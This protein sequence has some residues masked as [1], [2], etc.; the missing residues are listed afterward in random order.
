MGIVY[1][2]HDPE[3]DRHVAIKILPAQ[4]GDTGELASRRLRRE[5][6]AMAKLSHPNLVPVFDVGTH[7]GHVYLA[8]EYVPGGTLRH[9]LERGGLRWTAIVDL[10]PAGR[11]RLWPPPTMRA[12]FTVTSN[13]TT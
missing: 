10:V 6:Q 7:E 4:H 2:A 12:S 9:R 1:E 3:L 11:T 5:A 8:M 13:Q